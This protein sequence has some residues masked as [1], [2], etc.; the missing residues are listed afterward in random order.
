MPIAGQEDMGWRTDSLDLS[1]L[2]IRQRQWINQRQD[3]C[4]VYT[5]RTA[6][7]IV[8]CFRFTVAFSPVIDITIKRFEHSLYH[9]I[10]DRG[11]VIKAV[12]EGSKGL[13]LGL[14]LTKSS[15]SGNL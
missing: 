12:P 4:P 9:Q 3:V 10:F 5:N 2:F 1:N 13:P 7:P 15:S 11:Y 14:P 8:S 6:I